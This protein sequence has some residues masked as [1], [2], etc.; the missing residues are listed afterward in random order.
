MTPFTIELLA[1]LIPAAVVLIGLVAIVIRNL[2]PRE[3]I[4][5]VSRTVTLPPYYVPERVV[6]V[7]IYK[8][9]GTV[10]VWVNGVMQRGDEAEKANMRAESRKQVHPSGVGEW[11]K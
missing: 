11:L 10:E 8:T 1:C 3:R 5:T 6:E 2:L 9:N 7:R 4:K